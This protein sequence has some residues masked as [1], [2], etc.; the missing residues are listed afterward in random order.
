MKRIATFAF[1][2]LAAIGLAASAPPAATASPLAL[3]PGEIV[4]LAKAEEWV[5]IAPADLLVME[6][7]ADAKGRERRVII[8]LMPPP[9]SQGWVGNVRKLAA[10]KWCDGTSI[11]RVQDN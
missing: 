5:A 1:A 2:L 9:F 8:Q 11:N 6:L 7:A 4:G 10:A 3:S